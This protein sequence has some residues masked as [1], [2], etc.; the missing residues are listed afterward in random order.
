MHSYLNSFF[1][2]QW[3]HQIV[4][5]EC[6]IVVALSEWINLQINVINETEFAG[7][8]GTLCKPNAFQQLLETPQVMLQLMQDTQFGTSQMMTR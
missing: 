1:C 3:F 5:E 2:D 8:A 7:S 4:Q 6:K